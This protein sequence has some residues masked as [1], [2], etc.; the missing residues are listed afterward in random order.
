MSDVL[1]R[2]AELPLPPD[3]DT[4]DNVLVRV[5][6][7]V[8][9]FPVYGGG[10]IRERRVNLGETERDLIPGMRSKPHGDRDHYE[11]ASGGK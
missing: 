3:P 6:K 2:D 5:D 4:E 11:S 1:S 8:K 10:L 9:H 7:L